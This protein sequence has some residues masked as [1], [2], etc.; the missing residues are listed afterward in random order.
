[1]NA[2]ARRI[3]EVLAEA[4]YPAHCELCLAPAPAGDALCAPCLDDL[5]RVA[6]PCARCASPLPVAG[7]CP[8]CARRPPVLERIHAPW[9]YTWPLDRLVL[10]CKHTGDVRSERVLVSLARVVAAGRGRAE[11]GE[12]PDVVVPVPL[13]PVRLRQRGFNQAQPLARAAADVLGLPVAPRLARRIRATES[14]QGLGAQ[15]RRRNVRDAFAVD[16]SAFAGLEGARVLLVDDVVTTGATLNSLAATLRAAGARA[17][18][19]LA[20]ARA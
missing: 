15:A 7:E 6:H 12:R 17:V 13:H 10:G 8:A 19:A 4:L 9:V 11:C 1:M 16:A 3:R 2:Q 14:Q 20:L 5:Q 18:E